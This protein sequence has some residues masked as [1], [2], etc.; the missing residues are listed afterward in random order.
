MIGSRKLKNCFCLALAA[1][2]LLSGCATKETDFSKTDRNSGEKLYLADTEAREIRYVAK[3]GVVAR[4]TPERRAEEPAPA[5]EE[6]LEPIEAEFKAAQT[7]ASLEEFI[8]KYAPTTLAFVAVQRLAGPDIAAANWPAAVEIFERYRADFPYYTERINEIIALLEAPAEGLTVANLGGGINTSQSEYNPVISSDGRE[9]YFA[10]DCGECSGGEEVH[11]SRKG[12]DGRWENA[13]RFGEPLSSKGHEIPLAISSDNTTLAVF[14]HYD[15][16]LGRGD[17]FYVEKNQDGWGQ[18]QHYPSPLNSENFE[19]NAMYAADGKAILFIS[20][21]PGGI[22]D[23]HPK[24]SFYNGSSTGNTDIYVYLEGGQS[25]QAEVVNL[26]SVINTPNSE[27]SPYLHPDGKTLYFS[28]NG[29]PGLGGLDVYKAT[30]LNADSWTEWSKPVNLGKEINSSY[31]D[32]GYQVAAEGER[33]YFAKSSLTDSYGASDIYSI[34]LPEKAKPGGVITVTGVV[35]DPK[36]DPL[37]AE[38]R[39]DD[40]DK[41]KE[42]GYAL[43]DP[44]TGEY[45]IHLPSGG[46][47]GYYA[48]K[49]GYIGE[50]ENFDLRDYS[51]AYQEFV[52]DI[53]LY[54]IVQPTPMEP[55]PVEEAVEE[56]PPVEISMNNIFFD[57]DK[58]KLRSE[59]Y[60]EINRW[61]RMLNENEHIDLYISGHADSVGPDDYN[62]KLSERRALAVVDYLVEKGIDRDRLTAEGFGESQPVASNETEEGRQ[63]NRR[64]QV[65][66]LNSGR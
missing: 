58:A 3:D 62:R 46:N 28:S 53:V 48:D 47:Y 49:P 22:G 40:L 29:H 25:G 55:E 15:G 41:E 63:R 4:I 16:S 65:R 50:S 32:W 27:Y 24:G 19:S 12:P 21:R 1:L 33:A 5:E 59:S 23:Y 8:K 39:W 52:L 56:A 34:T 54:P 31:D 61:A 14:G 37:I 45:I 35:S 38:I 66:I 10:R 9:I 7:P 11:V 42:V 2:F 57:F 64:V 13:R 36:G 30:R 17:I 60:M 43:S 18:L 51:D 6:I 26:G 20:E 44:I